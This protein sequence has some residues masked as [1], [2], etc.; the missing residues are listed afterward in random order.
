MSPNLTMTGRFAAALIAVLMVLV[1]GLG[2]GSDDG[3]SAPT[4][5]ATGSVGTG[6]GESTPDLQSAKTQLCSKLSGLEADLADVSANGTEA[7]EDVLTRLGSAAAALE[8][9]A[10]T[11]SSA[12][13]GDAAT[14]ARNLASDLE[15]LSTSGGEEARTQAGEAVDEVQ[16]LTEALQCP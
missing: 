9:G 3:G 4:G 13:A 12:G 10:G 16:Q 8:A 1:S 5:V 14:A 7:G 2:C 11:L 15:A 6:T